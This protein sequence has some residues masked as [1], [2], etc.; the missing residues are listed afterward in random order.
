MSDSASVE[1]GGTPRRRRMH[2]A[3]VAV[4]V[5]VL[6]LLRR[7]Q[8]SPLGRSPARPTAFSRPRRARS[9]ARC[10]RPRRRSSSRSS[11]RSVWRRSAASTPSSGSCAPRSAPRCAVHLRVAVEGAGGRVT[12]ALGGASTAPQLL[13]HPARA[14]RFLRT[15]PK[16]QQLTVVGLL[17]APVRSL[18]Y[19]ERLPGSTNGYVVYAEAAL[20]DPSKVTFA[21]DSPFAGLDFAAY[22]G[23]VAVAPG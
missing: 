13:L 21:P 2:A 17:A 14:K 20:P 4:L 6:A 8:S 10:R 11:P 12:R 22:F 15:V 16:S 1:G 9:P 3:S 18:G 19:A 7:S 5:V 23:A